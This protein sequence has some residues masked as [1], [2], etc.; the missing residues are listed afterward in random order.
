MESKGVAQAFPAKWEL[1]G[2]HFVEHR[3]KGKQ[4]GAGVQFP[5]AHL[6]R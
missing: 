6:L 5:P 4:V 2:G 3:P 1:A